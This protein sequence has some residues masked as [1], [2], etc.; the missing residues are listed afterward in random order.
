MLAHWAFDTSFDYSLSDRNFV[1]DFE[2]TR[3]ITNTALVMQG[4]NTVIRNV[5]LYLRGS[6]P[7]LFYPEYSALNDASVIS[8]YDRLLDA[9]KTTYWTQ[10]TLDPDQPEKRELT[11][12]HLVPG[13]TKT[14]WSLD[15]PLRQRSSRG[16]AQTITPYADGEISSWSRAVRYTYPPTEAR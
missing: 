15:C 13:A 16:G 12:V 1:R 7:V 10:L 14:D 11:F 2:K 3:D 5:S 4:S 8:L 9:G 6:Q